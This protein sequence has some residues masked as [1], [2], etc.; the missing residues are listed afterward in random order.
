MNTSSLFFGGVFFAADG[1]R[2]SCFQKI[3]GDLRLDKQKEPDNRLVVSRLIRNHRESKSYA[4]Q[5]ARDSRLGPAWSKP[6]QRVD[7]LL[8]RP[9]KTAPANRVQDHHTGKT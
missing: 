7:H 5:F 1:K 9:P 2:R 4:W 6:S 3:R 8:P